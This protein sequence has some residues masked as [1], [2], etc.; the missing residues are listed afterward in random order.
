MIQT[1]CKCLILRT[2]CF[3]VDL[4]SIVHGFCLSAFCAGSCNYCRCVLKPQLER[5]NSFHVIFFYYTLVSSELYKSLNFSPTLYQDFPEDTTG[6]LDKL[7]NF[8]NNN[9]DIC[10]WI[11]LTVVA[12]QVYSFPLPTHS[13]YYAFFRTRACTPRIRKEK[14]IIEV[15]QNY[16]G[17]HLLH[18]IVDISLFSLH[19]F[20]TLSKINFLNC[21]F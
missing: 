9:F 19:K 21:C 15:F 10:K 8:V 12:F 13:L 14:R 18:R 17:P 20:V 6:N 4:T 2:Y 5:G 3:F 7:R 11:G 1:K 16:K